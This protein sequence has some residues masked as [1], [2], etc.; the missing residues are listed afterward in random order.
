MVAAGGTGKYINKLSAGNKGVDDPGDFADFEGEFGAAGVALFVEWLHGRVAFQTIRQKQ[1]IAV[2][3]NLRPGGQFKRTIGT[4]KI[5]QCAA[6]G[7]RLI[8][9][10]N[11]LNTM[12]TKGGRTMLTKPFI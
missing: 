11:R 1:H 9:F 8:L 12:W 3:A 6:M 10:L 7:A 5:K 4:L 2:G